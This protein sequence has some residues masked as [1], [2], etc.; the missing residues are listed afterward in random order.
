M[1]WRYFFTWLPGIPIAIINGSIRTYIYSEYLIALKAHQ[2]SVLS[3][4][5]LFGL[6]VW[7]V[8]PWLRL[9]SRKDS[10]I[11]GANWVLFTILFEFIFGHFAMGHSWETLF[12]DYNLFSGRLWVLVLVWILLAPYVIF[13]IKKNKQT[14]PN[15]A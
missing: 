15:N 1:N 3:F 14:H 8:F 5:I 2:L 10:F 4:V 11:I 12:H 7:L 9:K 13:Q 6:Y